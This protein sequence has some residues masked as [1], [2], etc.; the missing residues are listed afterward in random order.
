MTG[1]TNLYQHLQHKH[2]IEKKNKTNGE[3]QKKLTEMLF[4]N[5]VSSTIS[6]TKDNGQS[7][8]SR[9]MV[10]WLCRD[11]MPLMTVEN[12]GFRDFWKY[13]RP[14][15]PLPSRKT[16]SFGA[17][18]DIYICMKNQLIKELQESDRGFITFDCLTDGFKKHSYCTY[19]YHHLVE[20]EMR[21]TVLKTSRLDHPHTSEKL[22]KDFKKTLIEFG[23]DKKKH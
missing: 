23:L 2:G 6:K 9:R 17:L 13:L 21:S 10:L 11:L 12:V 8:M 4:S 1:P 16:I 19:T 3:N 15:E 20:W 22:A 14:N 18:D 5:K 7:H